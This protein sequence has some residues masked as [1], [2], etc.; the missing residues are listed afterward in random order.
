MPER[1]WLPRPIETVPLRPLEPLLCDSRTIFF[2]RGG[3]GKGFLSCAVIAAFAGAQE[4]P[5][6]IVV[7]KKMRVGILDF[8]DNEDEWNSRL[9]GM[10]VNAASIP[11]YRSAVPFSIKAKTA[12]R[13]IKEWVADT[14]PDMVLVDSVI[15]A[16]G[17][18]DVGDPRS[19][20][21]FRGSM[22]EV[23]KPYL[24]LAH[25][26]KQKGPSD[27]PYGSVTWAN[28]ARLIWRVDSVSDT[29]GILMQLDNTKASRWMQA[30]DPISVRFKISDMGR[31][32]TVQ[33]GFATGFAVSALVDLLRGLPEGVTLEDIASNLDKTKD[34]IEKMI[35]RY[36]DIFEKKRRPAPG[37]PALYGLKDRGVF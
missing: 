20:E 6:P 9:T 3:V 12:M 37:R 11:Y 15:P 13:E 25:V 19:A 2:G 22:D 29:D 4:F 23:N 18:L 21:L 26:T 8:E 17:G 30:G 35:N 24:A 14:D 7:N 10:G 34:T 27:Y 36:P 16:V 28:N 5:P 31:R 32:I 1:I 33:S